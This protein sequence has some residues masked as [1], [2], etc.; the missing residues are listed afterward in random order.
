MRDVYITGLGK[1]LP[2]E[3]VGNDQMEDHLGCINGKP[4]RARERILKQ[5]G[6]RF[7]HYALD[8][9]QR[10]LFRTSEMAAFAIRDAVEHSDHGLSE[11][12]F[13]AAATTQADLL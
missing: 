8:T 11:I 4:S 12:D 10:P 5:N 6:I 13:I 2:G 9:Q 3:P 1:F 7:R